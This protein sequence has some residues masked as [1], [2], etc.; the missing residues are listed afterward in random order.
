[1]IDYTFIL[2]VK[3]GGHRPESVTLEKVFTAAEPPR[4]PDPIS[5]SFNGA[6][7]TEFV[8]TTIAR[9]EGTTVTLADIIA[10]AHG[11]YAEIVQGLRRTWKVRA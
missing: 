8:R 7:G 6:C 5:L 10:P 11:A 9:V 2:R 1:M 3:T 4:A